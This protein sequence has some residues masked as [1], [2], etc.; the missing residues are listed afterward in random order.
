MTVVNDRSAATLMPII[1][2]HIRPG[3]TILSDEW[4]SYA[5]LNSSGYTHLAVN[6]SENL[7][8]LLLVIT[9]QYI[10]ASH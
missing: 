2:T 5:R 4:R 1:R 7:L 9:C 8:I 6:H 3:T 10:V